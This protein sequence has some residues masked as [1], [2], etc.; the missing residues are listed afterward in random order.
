MHFTLQNGVRKEGNAITE[1][2]QINDKDVIKFSVSKKVGIGFPVYKI[3][4]AIVICIKNLQ[5]SS[6]EKGFR[7]LGL[8]LTPKYRQKKCFLSQY[9]VFVFL[10]F[11]IKIQCIFC[12]GRMSARFHLRGKVEVEK[13]LKKFSMA[14][15][16]L[17]CTNIQNQRNVI[18]TVRLL[19]E[20][21]KVK[22]FEEIT[23]LS[24]NDSER[25]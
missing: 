18:R 24:I 9:V 20:K 3:E 10:F 22:F 19:N 25:G 8:S 6:L 2:H 16:K 21:T 15:C 5:E 14:G 23:I 12:T 1:G 7:S 4:E 13:K 17:R 11:K